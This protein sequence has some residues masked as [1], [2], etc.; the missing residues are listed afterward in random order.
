MIS[1]AKEAHVY[2]EQNIQNIAS[3]R[4]QSINPKFID[5]VLNNTVLEYVGSKFP[6]RQSP[7]DIEATL[8]RYTDF[9][10]LKTTVSRITQISDKLRTS[11]FTKIPSN[12]VKVQ[13][14]ICNYKRPTTI[15]DIETKV[16]Y[17]VLITVTEKDIVLN[18][19]TLLFNYTIEGKTTIE[20]SVSFDDVIKTISTSKGMFYLYDTLLDRLRNL[21]DLDC[22]FISNNI[23]GNKV[24]EIDFPIGY[25]VNSFYSNNSKVAI[26][27][28]QYNTNCVKQTN[29]RISS[30]SLMP[31]FECQVALD[32]YYGRK[33]LHLNPIGELS[34]G[35]MLI[36]YTDFIPTLVE[37]NYLKKPKLFNIDTGQIPEIDLNKEFFDYAI[38]EFLL[39]LNS[40]NYEKVVNQ[41]VKNL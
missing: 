15:S 2:I 4:K 30:I 36:Y 17:R 40:P 27:I 39:I 37:I 10:I 12:C 33:N 6:D 29:G 13:T 5:M 32:D 26:S 7:K 34:D 31:S 24:I 19:L 9:N 11:V 35:N 38:K 21:C 18:T 14:A 28:Q 41:N 25:K 16:K 8:K 23:D 1:T 3:N 20:K 22:K